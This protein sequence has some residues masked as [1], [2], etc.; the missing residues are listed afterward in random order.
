M[1]SARMR[2][3]GG[4]FLGYKALHLSLTWIR[5]VMR[6]KMWSGDPKAKACLNAANFGGPF[7]SLKLL[8]NNIME[9][10]KPRYKSDPESTSWS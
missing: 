10:D 8:N 5:Y 1:I 9:K 6:P 2:A 3:I 7:K 4:L